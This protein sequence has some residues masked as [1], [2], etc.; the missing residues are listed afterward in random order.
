MS[1][2]VAT[3]PARSNVARL[4]R[5]GDLLLTIGLFGT[6]LLMIL[7]VSPF[8]LD[9]FLSISI[10]LSLLTLLVILYVKEPADFT[11]FPTLLLFLTLFRLSLNIAS[12]R[13]ILLDGYAGHIIEAFGNFV[14]RGTYVVGLV[15]PGH[16]QFCGYHEG[17][18]PYRRSGRPIHVGRHARQANGHRC[19]VECGRDHRN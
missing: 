13:L 16:H 9:G 19:R 3:L 17:C 5:N 7:P 11:S 14:V 6:V 8:L 1:A 18:W 2:A 10:T 15:H 12:T 4:F